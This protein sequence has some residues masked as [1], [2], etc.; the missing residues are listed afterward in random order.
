MPLA[1][2]RNVLS[3]QD[4]KEIIRI[5]EEH[6]E[7]KYA[8]VAEEYYKRSKRNVSTST[9]SSIINNR[10]AI[11][12]DLPYKSRNGRREISIST[13]VLYKVEEARAKEKVIT[14]AFVIEKAWEQVRKHKL[15]ESLYF[16]STE[17]VSNIL[18]GQK[19]DFSIL[20]QN[21]DGGGSQNKDT[22]CNIVFFV[23]F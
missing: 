5:K 11:L 16:F 13:E 12:N 4:K 20:K 9:I 10:D 21:I 7:L 3:N 14:E 17:W 18:K 8:E 23:R 15:D 19:D 22:Q 1:R 2:K 6:P